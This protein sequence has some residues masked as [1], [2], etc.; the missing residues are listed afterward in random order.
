MKI[1]GVDIKA[2][3]KFSGF[4][5]E[6]GDH[7]NLIYGPNEA[8]KSTLLT[9]LEFMLF[10]AKKDGHTRKYFLEAHDQYQPWDS[11]AYEGI[12][13][14]S[15][16][17]DKRDYEV[18]RNFNKDA[19]KVTI[20]DAR[21]GKDLS[22]SFPADKRDEI[23]FAQEILGIS[24]SIFLNTIMIPQLGLKDGFNADSKELSAQIIKSLS[25]GA[26]DH[27]ADMAL[28]QLDKALESIG[29]TDRGKR[30]GELVAA[31]EKLKAER[32]KAARQH[33]EL[34]ELKEMVRNLGKREGTLETLISQ[35]EQKQAM[36]RR[37]EL[38]RIIKKADDLNSQLKENRKKAEDYLEFRQFPLD[39]V[40][41]AAELERRKNEFDK[42]FAELEET[43]KSVF[44]KLNGYNLEL[45]P[46]EK[47]I[48]VE[49]ETKNRAVDLKYQWSSVNN[50]LQQVRNEIA[51]EQSKN[52]EKQERHDELHE[53]FSAL[54][55]EAEDRLQ[56]LESELERIDQEMLNTTTGARD[57]SGET[58][59][60]RAMTVA[61]AFFSLIT[62]LAASLFAWWDHGASASMPYISPILAV[63]ASGGVAATLYFRRSY[64][65]FK[66][67]FDSLQ[68][69]Y[70]TYID[71]RKSALRERSTVFSLAG[72]QNLKEFY[73][74]LSEY[75]NLREE[76][77]NSAV[78]IV[79]KRLPRLEEKEKNLRGE[80][81]A[82]LHKVG[83][84]KDSSTPREG[85]VDLF[86]SN[87]E[88]A[89]RAAERVDSTHGELEKLDQK[90]KKLEEEQHGNQQELKRIYQQS[91]TKG[92]ADFHKHREGKIA[93]DKYTA[94]IKSL[95]ENLEL[96][97]N[98]DSIADLKNELA[99]LEKVI[100]DMEADAVFEGPFKMDELER[101]RIQLTS[102]RQ[103][104]AKHEG[105]IRQMLSGYRDPAE[106]D[107]EIENCRAELSLIRKRREALKLASE[108][109]VE[110][111]EQ[112][113]ADFA[114]MIND[115]ISTLIQEITMGRYDSVMTSDT[116]NISVR[117]PESGSIVPAEALSC[118]T[119]DQLFF[120]AR[121]AIAEVISDKEMPLPLLFDDCFVEYDI[122]RSREA[123]RILARLADN[124][125]ILFF[126]CHE[127]E[128]EIAAELFDSS[129]AD[130]VDLS[131]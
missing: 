67:R 104:R 69:Q 26:D 40:D 62:S 82:I 45:M 127:R 20:H 49:P 57:L 44:E 117:S 76:L 70:D 63:L 129:K 60:N 51:A 95:E 10:G 7:F 47:Y 100:E 99:G 8:G 72:V 110:S 43:K 66:K 54:G 64:A 112:L 102:A 9:F 14:F 93:Y 96:L 42:D 121:L 11:S 12:L 58:G 106:F 28:N 126:T 128:K 105:S 21:L 24:R 48:D 35:L 36:E 56:F 46:L 92:Y 131:R 119:R 79:E 77:S 73:S 31:M 33:T 98:D 75:E 34:A 55:D 122:E 78:R 5:L 116:F 39:F 52:R 86:V 108:T 101:A 13:R 27:G 97:L 74:L 38:L 113:H 71:D 90:R 37:D 4:K 107:L 2:F 50:E 6:F 80:L 84:N 94:S 87:L 120:A 109:I 53:L 15:V 30:A 68:Q 22:S 23:L 81:L 16:P 41:E 88:K 1:T 83:L 85:D 25:G 18:Y 103:E 114:P 32:E 124:R 118:G 29:K 65:S 91:G 111:R 59:K 19:D 89:E 123:F 3:G 61:F 17:S 125:Q 115:K 130:I